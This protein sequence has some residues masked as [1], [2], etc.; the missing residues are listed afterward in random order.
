MENF[1]NFGSEYNDSYVVVVN[2]NNVAFS[3]CN[4]KPSLRYAMRSAKR[5]DYVELWY[6][7]GN[8]KC[9]LVKFWN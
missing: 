4:Q 6:Q 5:G 1:S 7:H 2:G 3:N 8:G 9:V